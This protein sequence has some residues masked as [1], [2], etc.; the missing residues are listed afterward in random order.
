M[1]TEM[2]MPSMLFS[3]LFRSKR[4]TLLQVMLVD[5]FALRVVHADVVFS[6]TVY[7]IRFLN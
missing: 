5:S 2:R 4:R 6:G 3:F 1:V 7:Y